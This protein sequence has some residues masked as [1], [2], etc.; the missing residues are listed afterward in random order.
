MKRAWLFLF[1]ACLWG[2]EAVTI[3]FRAVVG[4]AELAC[5]RKYPGIGTTRSTITPRDFR[6]YVHNLRL[7]DEAGKEVPVELQ[8]DDWQLDDVA[9]LDFEDGTGACDNGTPETRREVVGKVPGGGKYRGLRF[10]LGVPMEKNHTDLLAMPSPL[11]LTAMGWMWN[12]GRTFA[13]LDFSST[14]APRGWTLHLGSTGCTPNDTMTTIPTKCAAPNR[15]EVELAGFDPAQ[16]VVLADLAAL[17]EG[18]NVDKVVKPLTGC[19][20]DRDTPACGPVLA[21]FGLPFRDRPAQAQ[22]FFRIGK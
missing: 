7:L 9:L 14:G 18:S 5:G 8:Q 10:T 15:P 17:L 22:T 12:S 20:A 3:R 1:T 4:E 11:N 13:R 16:D 21:R 6:F 2:Q 19:M